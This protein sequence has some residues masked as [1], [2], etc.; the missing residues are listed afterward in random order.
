MEQ[1]IDSF[2]VFRR[3]REDKRRMIAE[4]TKHFKWAKEEM[5]KWYFNYTSISSRYCKPYVLIC[6]KL[7]LFSLSL[8]LS[9]SSQTR[10]D[11]FNFNYVTPEPKKKKCEKTAKHIIS[12]WNENC[13]ESCTYDIAQRNAKTPNTWNVICGVH[14]CTTTTQFVDNFHSSLRSNEPIERENTP[15]PLAF[16]IEVVIYVVE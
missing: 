9:S 14:A 15:A 2:L 13:F 4:E 6:S 5:S 11:S 1:T 7:S 12:I 8:S 10:Y 3:L 16:G